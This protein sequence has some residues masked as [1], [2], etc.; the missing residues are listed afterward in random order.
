M[1]LDRSIYLASRSPRRRALLLQ[2]GVRF[3]VMDANVDEVL[4]NGEAPRNYVERLA[5]AK[6]E[7]GWRRI[8]RDQAQVFRNPSPDFSCRGGLELN[9]GDFVAARHPAQVFVAGRFGPR[10]QPIGDGED[11]Q[12]WHGS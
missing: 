11:V 1:Q 9:Q 2:I 10:W 7:A 6:A 3:E 5:R 4:V 8:E 12:P